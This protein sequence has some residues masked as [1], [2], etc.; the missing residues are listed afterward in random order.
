M[1]EEQIS[2]KTLGENV[3]INGI[4]VTYYTFNENT[5]ALEVA[6][7]GCLF[8]VDVTACCSGG[9]HAN[10]ILDDEH[11]PGYT[12]CENTIYFGAGCNSEGGSTLPDF[13]N[14][15][16]TPNGTPNPGVS[17]DDLLNNKSD[18]L[19]NETGDYDNNSVGGYDATSYP[20]FNPTQENW[21]NIDNVIS[22][23][24]FVGYRQE[25]RPGSTEDYLQCMDFAKEQIAVKDFEISN[26]LAPNQT[27]QIYTEQNGT[28]PNGVAD[29]ISYL[30]YA[31]ENDIPVIVGMGSD[32]NGNFF[33]FYDNATKHVNGGTHSENK[34]YY[35]PS[36]GIIE[37]KSQTWY[38]ERPGHYDYIITQIRKSK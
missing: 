1:T 8:Y 2:R 29:G 28:D 16:G 18:I 3:D 4:D 24:E 6:D 12:L 27:I 32:S 15:S 20:L 14:D 25:L 10:G 33:R 36:E 21:P 19:N 7:N 38:A 17:F 11:C 34:L 13:P 37:G 9:N 30:K 22:Q 23:N 31:F 26:Y 35:K 5:A